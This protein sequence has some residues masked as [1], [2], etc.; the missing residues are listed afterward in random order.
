M[1]ITTTL[2]NKLIRNTGFFETAQTSLQEAYKTTAGNFDG[3]GMSFGPLQC[4]LGQQSLQPWMTY[5]ISN[6]NS[7]FTSVFGATKAAI[8]KDVINTMTVAQQIAWGNSISANDKHKLIDEWRTVFASMGAKTACQNSLLNTSLNKYLDRATDYASAFG[9]ISTQ[10]LAYLFDS[11]VNSWSFSKTTNEIAIE[12][13][14]NANIYQHTEGKRMPDY[15]RL[16]YVLKYDRNSTRR[17]VIR[18]GTGKYNGLTYNKA[19]YG[20]DYDTN[21]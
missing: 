1:A 19:D 21:F 16:A 10:G 11:C 6:N 17:E 13:S 7:E 9:I 18:Q 20:L 14:Q 8:F 2:K 5:Y 3:Q 15:D 4:N 12:I